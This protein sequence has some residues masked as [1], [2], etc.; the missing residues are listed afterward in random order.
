MEFESRTNVSEE[1]YIEMIRLKTAVLLACCLKTGAIIGGASEKDADSL[2]EFGIHIGLA[3]QLQDDLLD[4]YGNP[5]TFGKNI[6][7]DIL[8]N[9]KTFLLAN[10]LKMANKDQLTALTDWMEKPEFIASEKISAVTT[11][12]NELGIKQLTEKRIQSYYSTSMQA[13]SSLSID[14]NKA[15]ILKEVTDKLMFRQV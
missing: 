9:K 1:E 10:A 6:G 7:G 2:Y 4:V 11:I 5:E 8:S 3:F 12:F 13:L 14:I 15:S